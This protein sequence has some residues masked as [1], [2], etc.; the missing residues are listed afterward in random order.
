MFFLAFNNTHFQFGAE[1]LTWRSYTVA[2]ALLITSRVELIDKS[3]FAK[4]AFD[5][6]FETFVIYISALKATTIHS[7]WV[8]QIAAL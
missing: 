1:K 2:D 6:N 8:A 5:R 4:V 3:Q 7:F